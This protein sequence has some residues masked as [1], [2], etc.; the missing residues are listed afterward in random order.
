VIAVTQM[1]TIGARRTFPCFDEPGLKA[2]FDIILRHRN[3]Q[4]YY[5]ISNMP[6]VS[7]EVITLDIV[8]KN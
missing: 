5:G 2:T 4:G 7:Y 6:V 3:D 8:E 1:E